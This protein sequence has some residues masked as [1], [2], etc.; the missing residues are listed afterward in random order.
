MPSAPS[1]NTV[2]WANGANYAVYTPNMVAARAGSGTTKINLG[3]GVITESSSTVTYTFPAGGT[4][5]YISTSGNIFDMKDVAGGGSTTLG[6]NHNNNG[7]S[8]SLFAI[9]IA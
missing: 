4:W 9:R 5:R 6:S 3:D 7:Y 8:A 2:N 1:V